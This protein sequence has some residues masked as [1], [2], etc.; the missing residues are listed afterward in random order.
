M[1]AAE[2]RSNLNIARNCFT[3]RCFWAQRFEVHVLH[4]I[5]SLC[6]HVVP[7]ALSFSAPPFRS[8]QHTLSGFLLQ[9]LLA[10]RQSLGVEQEMRVLPFSLAL[11]VIPTHIDTRHTIVTSNE[12]EAQVHFRIRRQTFFPFCRPT[13]T[14]SNHR[15]NS[16][17][18]QVSSSSWFAS[19]DKTRQDEASPP[20]LSGTGT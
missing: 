12:M 6:K 20:W 19:D 7:P 16:N 1:Q 4:L 10:G 13:T 18:C 14:N 8:I 17:T 5:N 9:R 11:G 2:Q 15:S 3:C